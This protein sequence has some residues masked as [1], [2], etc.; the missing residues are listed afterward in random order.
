MNHEAMAV[1]IAL[2]LERLLACDA[3]KATLVVVYAL[4]MAIQIRRSR[5]TCR[6]RPKQ[7]EL[8]PEQKHTN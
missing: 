1:E 4:N 2:S 6:T 3:M 8:N 5:E 7:S